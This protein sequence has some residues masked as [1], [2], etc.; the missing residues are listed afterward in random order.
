MDENPIY[1]VAN[2]FREATHC[3]GNDRNPENASLQ[4]DYS[5]RLVPR[6]HNKDGCIPEETTD[7]LV[8][9]S[10]DDLDSLFDFKIGRQSSEFVLKPRCAPHDYKLV[11]RVAQEYGFERANQNVMPFLALKC[12]D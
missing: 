4:R 10:L 2:D 3:R 6:W 12:T 5:K 7:A 11:F 1:S 8:W 9:N